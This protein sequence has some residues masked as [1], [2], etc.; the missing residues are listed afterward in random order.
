MQHL[1]ESVAS[2]ED[3]FH[4]QGTSLED[5]L[6]GKTNWTP[7]FRLVLGCVTTL[8]GYFGWT[9]GKPNFIVSTKTI[10]C[11]ERR[12]SEQPLC[13]CTFS[14][15]RLESFDWSDFPSDKS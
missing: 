10:Q 14:T 13:T 2:V 15:E 4:F 11:Q 9:Q 5:A 1:R 3:R 6:T 12:R 7:S 8:I